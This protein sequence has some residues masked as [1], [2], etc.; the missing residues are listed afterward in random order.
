MRHA[1]RSARN[2]PW[3]TLNGLFY[4]RDYRRFG[5][6]RLSFA[7]VRCREAVG[8]Y[9]GCSYGG[10]GP[11]PPSHN[12]RVG[13]P[14]DWHGNHTNRQSPRPGDGVIVGSGQSGRRQNQDGRATAAGR[15]WHASAKVLPGM[16][17]GTSH[18]K[19]GPVGDDPRRPPSIKVERIPRCTPPSVAH[20][21]SRSPPGAGTD[22]NR[23]ILT[24]EAEPSRSFHHQDRPK[25]SLAFHGQPGSQGRPG[26]FVQP[27]TKSPSALDKKA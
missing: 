25:I 15:D 20:S 4:G 23:T 9:P 2:E 7:P 1:L 22:E 26:H 11:P 5:R 17:A 14:D 24:P 18:P 19:G 27:P 13:L 12:T 16:G 10:S 3:R 21:S 8:E 6:E